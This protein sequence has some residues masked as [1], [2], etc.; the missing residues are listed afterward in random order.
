MSTAP[1]A[2]PEVIG[3]RMTGALG[4]NPQ[5]GTGAEFLVGEAPIA[6]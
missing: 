6:E 3:G 1:A 4:R 2:D 5:R